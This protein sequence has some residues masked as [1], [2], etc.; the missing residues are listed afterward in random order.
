MIKRPLRPARGLVVAV[1]ILLLASASL[2][3]CSHR[4]GWGLVLWTAP[5]GPIPAGS[6]VPVYIK[7]N[8]DK[9]YVVGSLDGKKKV[10]LP[11]WQVELYGTRGKARA[12]ASKFAPMAGLYLVAT[13]DGLPVR[14]EP[15]NLA[16]RVFRLH[17]GQSVKIL[18]KVKGDEVRTGDTVLQGDWYWVLADDGTRGYVFSN[19]MTLFDES[20]GNA[21]PPL[22]SSSTASSSAKVDILFS[23]SWRPE[24]FQS[25][26][27]DNRVDLDSFN[28]RFGLFADAVHRQIRIE[29]PAASQVF[30]YNSID[31]E[32]GVFVFQGTPL[33]IRFENERRLVAD[34]TG[35][36]V[37][38]AS[39]V[40]ALPGFDGD[41][42]ANS[43]GGAA[44][45]AGPAA[46][47]AAPVTTATTAT[48]ATTV[49]TA[50]D[51]SSPGSAGTAVFV[52]LGQDVR[53]AIRT[54]ELRRQRLL[55]LFLAK[56]AEWSLLVPPESAP[57]GGAPAAGGG[58]ATEAEAP[59]AASDE[60]SA[61]TSAGV[62]T[63]AVAQRSASRLT[64][65]GNGRFSW[66]RIDLVPAGYLP[67]LPPGAPATG[68]A[69]LRLYLGAPVQAAWEGVISFR[70]DN[71]PNPSWVDFLVRRDGDNLVLAPAAAPVDLE[72]R[73]AG[74]L[75]PLRF[76]PARRN[77]P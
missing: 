4:L 34:W 33:R 20:L 51:T 61:A 36:A 67:A 70:F 17:E 7:S 68:E 73:A 16:A 42:A 1:I 5:E 57:A 12:A 48:T 3:S 75:L 63:A 26:L 64:I 39:Q 47:A 46:Q 59:P 38:G 32:S 66:A 37:P 35:L 31:E 28:P 54:E 25:M 24:Y 58:S 29:L 45:G 30:Q 60:A 22:A 69:A 15:A 74:P 71:V 6:V 41:Q 18:A 72:V 77:S 21:P 40:N 10:E 14:G 23:R 76:A 2:V 65:S 19:T 11:L 56:G 8:I 13:R 53:D 55:D 27:D 52:V 43:P 49:A 9:V 50:I 44:G 62:D